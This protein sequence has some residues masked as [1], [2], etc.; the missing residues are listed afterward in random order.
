MKLFGDSS[1]AE[2]H[3]MWPIRHLNQNLQASL[4]KIQ[5]PALNL[6]PI[7]LRSPVGQPESLS[8]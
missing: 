5:I 6:R 7:E 8:F 1:K 2:F 4:I 3:K